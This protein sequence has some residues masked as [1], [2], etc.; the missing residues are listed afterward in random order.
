[1]PTVLADASHNIV[2]IR[3]GSVTVTQCTGRVRSARP[4]T[5]RPTV[6][7]WKPR[8]QVAITL[9]RVVARTMPAA[10][11]HVAAG[12][13]E[14]DRPVVPTQGVCQHPFKRHVLHTRCLTATPG[15]ARQAFPSTA[16]CSCAVRCTQVAQATEPVIGAPT[17]PLRAGE[18]HVNINLVAHT[19]IIARAA[20]AVGSAPGT[21]TQTFFQGG[22]PQA[23]VLAG[24]YNHF[25]LFDDPLDHQIENKKSTNKPECHDGAVTHGTAETTKGVL[26]RHSLFLQIQPYTE[27]ILFFL[28]KII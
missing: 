11:A 10:R 16:R 7:A 13:P 1:M 20:A 6:R 8:R 24:L 21:H 28:K 5:L 17:P 18:R 25:Y 9:A 26:G 19:I 27:D 2:R 22:H 14:I 12:S 3:A 4:R 23:T 15:V